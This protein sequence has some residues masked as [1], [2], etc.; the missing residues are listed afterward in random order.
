[1]LQVRGF[2]FVAL[3]AAATAPVQADHGHHCGG[4]GGVSFSV[5]CQPYFGYNLRPRLY[6]AYY[7]GCYPYGAASYYGEYNP[8][9]IYYSPNYGYYSDYYLPPVFA[10]A[11]LLYGPRAV[12]QFL[13]TIDRPLVLARDDRAKLEPRKVRV[14]NPEYRR[15]ADQFL[16]QGDVL[17]REQKYAQAIDRYERASDMAPD[18]PE[19]QWRKGHTY[20]AMHRYELAAAAFK[21]ALTLKTDADRL[22]FTLTKLYGVAA[23]VKTTHLEA[24]AGETLARDDASDLYFLLGVFLHYDGQAERAEKFFVRA[25]ELAGADAAH[26]TAFLPKEPDVPVS[27]KELET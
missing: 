4:W 21:R 8:Y 3:L 14:S 17:F 13:G 19:A 26:L 6:G 7:G 12:Q 1:M 25:R 9:G 22:G 23:T 27:S 15:K 2:L 20:V 24:L 5:G 11:E 18:L 10:P 16:A